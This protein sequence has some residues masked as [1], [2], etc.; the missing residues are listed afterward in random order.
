MNNQDRNESRVPLV[1]LPDSYLAWVDG[2]Q[3]IPD[4]ADINLSVDLTH[5]ERLKIDDIR[6]NISKEDFTYGDF[7]QLGSS[8]LGFVTDDIRRKLWPKILRLT[9]DELN[10]VGEELNDIHTHIPDE[11]YQQI[12]KDVAR[13]G[14]HLPTNATDT[15]MANFHNDLTRIICW[16]LHRHPNMNYYQGYNDVA[17][18]ILIVMGLKPGLHVLEKISTEFLERFMEQT[19]EK[20][21]QELFFIFALL[22]RV[23]PSLLEH[24]ENVELFPHFALAE[25]TTWY[26]HKYSENR[27]LLHRLFDFFLSSP[28]LMP[29]YLSTIIVAHRANEI[30]NTT[31]D[32]GHTHKVLCTLPSTLPFED[33][34]TNAKTL[35][36]DY[37]PESIVKDVHD[38]D[39]KRRCKEQEWKLKAEAS[40]KYS[41]KQRQLKVSLPKSRLPYHFKSYRTITV[42]TI[43]AIGLYAFLKTGSGIN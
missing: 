40:R 1:S 25:Y 35:Y 22:E 12:L 5:S 36:H 37:P 32:M 14:S 41:E 13:S 29:L 42:V 33:L 43:L 10:Y 23:H 8:S 7:K 27:S 21:N 30:F 6:N 16:V 4:I 28:L 15:E 2:V 3:K 20:V 26:A 39:R 19:M 18:T 31:P 38:Y 24:L 9:D 34:L 11:V 17:A